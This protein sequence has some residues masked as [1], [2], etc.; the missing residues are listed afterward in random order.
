MEAF[1]SA[2]QQQERTAFTKIIARSRAGK[3][4]DVTL[5]DGSVAAN[6]ALRTAL[7]AMAGKTGYPQLFSS[8]GTSPKSTDSDPA[9]AAAAYTFLGDG[10]KLNDEVENET[11]DA[12]LAALKRRS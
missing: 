3:R 5:V 7:W 11:I 2:I 12:L 6:K 4:I 10:P 1:L 8:T 9:A